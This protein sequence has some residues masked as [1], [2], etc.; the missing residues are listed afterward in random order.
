MAN[1]SCDFRICGQVMDYPFLDGVTPAEDKLE[2]HSIFPAERLRAFSALYAGV[3]ENLV[4]PLLSPIMT[5]SE[6]L[7]G[8]PPAFILTAGLD[9]LRREARRY[10]SML[11][12][13][14][15]DVT[16]R[17]FDDCDHG[18]MIAGQARFREAR[19]A[20]VTWLASVFN[21]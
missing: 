2:P 10:A 1:A 3:P 16:V 8:L 19:A 17:Q 13:A 5:A 20:I 9:P 15:V 12:D 4:K 7:K 21:T 6:V 11:I 18:F 14:G